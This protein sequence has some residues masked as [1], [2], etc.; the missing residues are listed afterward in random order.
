MKIYWNENT[1]SIFFYLSNVFEIQES[2]IADEKRIFSDDLNHGFGQY[3]LG[4]LMLVRHLGQQ[5]L[6]REVAVY[7]GLYDITPN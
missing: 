6:R 4:D 5:L 3:G 1:F 7:F 2:V